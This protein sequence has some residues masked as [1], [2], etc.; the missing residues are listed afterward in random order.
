MGEGRGL[1]PREGQASTRTRQARQQQGIE[2]DSSNEAIGSTAAA[3]AAAAH[4]GDEVVPR[5]EAVDLHARLGVGA[6]D[7]LGLPGGGQEPD[8]GPGVA[9]D[10][11]QRDPLPLIHLMLHKLLR[12]VLGQASVQVPGQTHQSREKPSDQTAAI[13]NQYHRSPLPPVWGRTDSSMAVSARN[14][15]LPPSPSPAE[16]I[17]VWSQ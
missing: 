5:K 8:H 9:L 16:E 2:M 3:A 6:E 11:P 12:E 10:R 15:A 4:H 14:P 7:L 17:R 1:E 13:P